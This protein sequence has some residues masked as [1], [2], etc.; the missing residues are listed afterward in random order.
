MWWTPS[1][2]R[3]LQGAE[4]ALFREAL[5]MLV[6]LVRD[7]DDG[8][9]CQSGV[10]AFDTLQR[11]QKLAVLA[12]IGS[13]L[14]RQE[15]PKPVLTAVLEAAVAAV[16]QHVRD[17]VQMEIDDSELQDSPSWRQMVLTA[18]E[19]REIDAGLLE[20]DCEDF[21]EWDLAIDGLVAGVLWDEDWKDGDIFID[22][23]PQTS[24]QMKHL[25]GIADDYYVAIPPD[26]SEEE[27][28]R[29]LAKLWELTAEKTSGEG[30]IEPA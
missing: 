28:E 25:L 4:A 8:T 27:I 9:L 24:Q 22:A 23:D 13:A 10:S 18:C 16:Y 6:D 1:G 17:M 7:D 26:P 21:D 5:G 29:L 12:Q 19:E 3:T 11:G 20:P 30:P 2:E 14:L 15:E